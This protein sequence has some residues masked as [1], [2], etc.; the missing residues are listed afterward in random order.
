MGVADSLRASDTSDGD[1]G[2]HRS[3]V[4]EARGCNAGPTR[5]L[6]TSI[7]AP[8]I[9]SFR[10]QDGRDSFLNW[11]SGSSWKKVSFMDV[12]SESKSGTGGDGM[13]TPLASSTFVD[14]PLFV[15]LD[16]P[17]SQSSEVLLLYVFEREIFR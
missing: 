15:L 14:V 17:I 10:V 7:G 2:D 6:V 9:T 16:S 11:L 8:L 3:R 1:T 13:A 4:L 12:L 5:G